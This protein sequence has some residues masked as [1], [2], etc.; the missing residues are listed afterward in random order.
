MVQ[1]YHCGISLKSWNPEE[2]PWEEHAK[3]N[4]DCAFLQLMKGKKFVEEIQQKWKRRILIEE[5]TAEEMRMPVIGLETIT[6]YLCG[7][8]KQSFIGI[9]KV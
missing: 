9:E 8:K 3:W 6:I 4:P 1:C 2:R 5:T 7:G